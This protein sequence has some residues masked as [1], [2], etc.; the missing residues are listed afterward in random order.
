MNSSTQHK[1]MTWN[2]NGLNQALKRKTILNFLYKQS[3]DFIFLQ[4]T[5]LTV[6]DHV[7]LGCQWKG[8]IFFSSFSSQAR[9]VAT[10]ISNKVQFQQDRVIEDKAG[11][12]VI[13]RGYVASEPLV[14]EY[15][16]V[17][18][19][20]P[21]F[22]EPQFFYNLFLN[23]NY[24]SS[25]LIIGGD[26][27]LTLG[28]LDRSATNR[29]SH[30]AAAKVL[31]QEM[32]YHNL[33]DIWRARNVN[34]R[35]YSFYSHKHNSYS[36][37]DLFYIYSGKQHV[38]SFCDYLPRVITDHSPLVMLVKYGQTAGKKRWRFINYLLNDLEYIDFIN[39]NTEI[40][41]ELNKNTASISVIWDCLKAFLRGL[42]ISYTSRKRKQN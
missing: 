7:K 39:T 3:V 23:L 26:L 2:V 25:E 15:I 1:Y 30:T 10:L 33:I 29:L 37:I 35:K 32:A 17:N 6:A 21:N 16:L 4:E 13:V 22:D 40:F 11:R 8:Q 9:G 28:I 41:L 34:E 36:R 24:P 38:V 5:H 12:F 27:N 31:K 18:V 19:Y 42:T 20:G 14:T